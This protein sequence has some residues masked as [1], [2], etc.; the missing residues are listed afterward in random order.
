MG[1]DGVDKFVGQGQIG[2]GIG[3]L[4]TIV[5]VI[6]ATESLS[7]TMT[8][9][10]HRGHAIE[11]ETVE[12]VFLQPELAVGQ[13]EIKHGILAI[14]KAQGIP[15]GML[16]LVVAIEV[17]VARAIKAAQALDLVFHCMGVDNVH[18]DS[19]ALG[20]GVVDEVL[21]LLGGAET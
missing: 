6:I 10:Q 20:M 18:D 17:Q 16:A 8:V 2:D 12:L 7:Q 13:Q 21:Q 4:T 1:I 11:A 15:C 9:I 3:V 14:V 19:H 5:V